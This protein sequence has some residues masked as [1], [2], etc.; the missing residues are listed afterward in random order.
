[1]NA[2]TRPALCRRCGGSKSN[3]LPGPQRHWHCDACQDALCDE[4]ARKRSACKSCRRDPNCADCKRITAER[5]RIGARKGVITRAARHTHRNRPSHALE[6]W[7]Q[8][9]Q[10]DVARA[11]RAGLLPRLSAAPYAC[12]D[13]G[14]RATCY[15]H[16]DYGRPLAVEP[17][18]GPCNH[19]RGTALWPNPADFQFRK[20]T[21]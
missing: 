12:V 16:R 8:K 2:A 1:M 13:C 11:V 18:C 7:Q 9:A 6:F 15:D 14:E 5:R 20:L 10:G 21:D 19:R 3:G 17:V 4:N